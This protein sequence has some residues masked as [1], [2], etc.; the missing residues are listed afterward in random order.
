MS[1]LSEYDLAVVL[2]SGSGEGRSGVLVSTCAFDSAISVHAACLSSIKK[3]RNPYKLLARVSATRGS[4]YVS[5]ISDFVI[6]P[7]LMVGSLYVHNF[8]FSLCC[9]EVFVLQ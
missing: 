1:P 3:R 4:C 8:R 9:N 5:R 2:G 6:I 7:L